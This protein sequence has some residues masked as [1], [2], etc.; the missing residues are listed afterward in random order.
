[1]EHG[2]SDTDG[3]DN[4]VLEEKPR[5]MESVHKTFDSDSFI[6]AQYVLITVNLSSSPPRESSGYV[7]D[8]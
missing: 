5:A 8:F 3:E 6:K 2:W 7:L 1:V 4:E